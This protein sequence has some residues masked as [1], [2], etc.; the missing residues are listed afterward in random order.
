MTLLTLLTEKKAIILKRWL[1]SILE[2]YP[3]DT[4]KF[5]KKQKDQFANPVG[6][7][8]SK[9]TENLFEELLNEAE[10]IPEKVN[11]ILDRI[12]RIR[13]IQDLCPSDAI[14]FI[15]PLKKSVREVLI[16]EDR[17]IGCSDE[18]FILE[19][20]IDKLVLM[21]FDIYMKCREKM[22]EISANHSRNQVSSLL[23]KNGL[24]CEVPEW[25]PGKMN[26]N[27]V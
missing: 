23:R 6:Y 4:K 10:L 15:Y 5:F 1:D 8:L 25:T 21:S 9:E 18:F 16:E 7:T 19:A 26:D 11:P 12:I 17:N 2:M 20:K 27:T 22:Y 14:S 3:P 13:A 24:V